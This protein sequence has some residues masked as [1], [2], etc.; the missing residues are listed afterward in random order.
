LEVLF[1]RQQVGIDGSYHPLRAFSGPELRAV[2]R[3]ADP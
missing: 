1:G 3:L 2:R